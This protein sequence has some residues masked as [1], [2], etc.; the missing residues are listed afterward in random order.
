MAGCYREL[1]SLILKIDKVVKTITDGD[2]PTDF[3]ERADFKGLTGLNEGRSM[4]L[5]AIAEGVETEEQHQFLA[6]LRTHSYQGYLCQQ[7]AAAGGV[8]PDAAREGVVPMRFAD[9]CVEFHPSMSHKSHI[10]YLFIFLAAAVGSASCQTASDYKLSPNDVSALT[11]KANDG[12]VQAQSKLGRAYLWGETGSEDDK[13]AFEWLQKAVG[14]G[15]AEAQFN[16]GAM[17]A[18][19]KGTKMDATKAASLFEQSAEAGFAPAQY[20]M[21][22]RYAYGQGVPKDEAK[23]FHWFEAAAKQGMV[24]AELGAAVGLANGMGV[25]KDSSAALSWYLK[26]A[27]AGS[28]DGE[29]MAGGMLLKGEGT[30]ADPNAAILWL[31][32]AAAHGSVQ[33]TAL[34]G[35]VYTGTQG[36]P[37]DRVAAYKWFWIVRE[38]GHTEV[39][40]A[41]QSQAKFLSPAQLADAKKQ[42]E[43]FLLLNGLPV[44]K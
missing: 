2:V 35:T 38:E 24:A 5:L 28:P 18:Q 19:G 36:V 4:G 25:T 20:N 29:T 6:S 17:Y 30:A 37:I 13:K 42:A 11:A 22:V 10:A 7:A 8:Q 14:G 21:G 12:D 43:S 31:T 3:N 26:A 9:S 27:E 16:L 33:A 34:L 39:E 32:K 44:T 41:L 1:Y 15:D 23:A 40:P